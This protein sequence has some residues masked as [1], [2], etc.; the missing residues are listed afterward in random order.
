MR[1]HGSRWYNTQRES[2]N[3]ISLH[4]L[5]SA[6]SSH[7]GCRGLIEAHSV[8]NGSAVPFRAESSPVYLETMC[9]LCS[10]SG[11]AD[12][13][14]A[15]PW[16]GFLSQLV[17]WWSALQLSSVRRETSC[18]W[19]GEGGGGGLGSLIEFDTGVNRIHLTFVHLLHFFLRSLVFFG[20]RRVAEVWFTVMSGAFRNGTLQKHYL[21]SVHIPFIKC[22]MRYLI[23][24][25][26]SLEYKK[27]RGRSGWECTIKM[28]KT[29]HIVY[30]I[31][32]NT[33]SD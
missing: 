18:H 32:R 3:G 13:T 11:A 20:F 30:V 17:G 26:H 8:L 23:I 5:K 29:P 4:P 16:N 21:N 19:S 24:K 10:I 1:F 27:K 6:F 12:N 9:H 22:F 7:N 31:H 25:P 28:L 15:P 33:S 14:V 2:P